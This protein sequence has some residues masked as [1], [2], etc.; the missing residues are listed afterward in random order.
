MNTTTQNTAYYLQIVFLALV[1]GIGLQIA[2]AWTPPNSAPPTQSVTAPITASNVAQTKVGS[3]SVNNFSATTMQLKNVPYTENT[4]CPTGA[5]NGLMG[6]DSAGIVLSCQ[7]GVWK[8]AG[9]SSSATALTSYDMLPKGALAGS[10]SSGVANNTFGHGGAVGYS[11]EPAYL[12]ATGIC[13]CPTGFT[14]I[15]TGQITL[16]SAVSVG[17][18]TSRVLYSC[19]KA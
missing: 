1:I 8:K 4:T 11:H 5:E 15:G 9:G 19:I 3:L 17:G 6:R 7:G 12:S 2:S 13:G 14:V 16:V 10:C 18:E